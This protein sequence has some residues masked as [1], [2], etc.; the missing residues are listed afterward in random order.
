[1]CFISV[2]SQLPHSSPGNSIVSEPGRLAD[3]LSDRDLWRSFHSRLTT[4]SILWV[5]TTRKHFT[6]YLRNILMH[7]HSHFQEI[8][9]HFQRS[10]YCSTSFVKVTGS[11]PLQFQYQKR[12]RTQAHSTLLQANLPIF[13]FLIF[14]HLYGSNTIGAPWTLHLWSER[15]NI[16]PYKRLGWYWAEGL[17]HNSQKP[18]KTRCLRFHKTCLRIKVILHC[19]LGWV[20]L[21]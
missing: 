10:W 13:F 19:V 6:I 9:H 12:H 11:I 8:L 18:R 7:Y 4:K 1:M 2:R 14:N 21:R 17:F 20:N 16:S 15:L 5:K 3:F